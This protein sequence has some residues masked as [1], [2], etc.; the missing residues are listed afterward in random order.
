MTIV[1][2]ALDTIDFSDLEFYRVTFQGG[3]FTKALF[4]G[5]RLIDCSM[6]GTELQ[7]ASFDNA[8]IGCDFNGAS[9]KGATFL[10]ARFVPRTEPDRE[11]QRT[12]FKSAQLAD[13]RFKCALRYVDFRNAGFN[14]NTNFEG[15]DLRHA[16]LDYCEGNANFK[17]ANMRNASLKGSQL[18]KAVL[19]EADLSD[20]DVDARTNFHLA[21]VRSCKITRYTLACL[22]E[23]GGLTAG[24]RMD[25]DIVDDVAT[26]RRSYTGVI[27]WIYLMSLALFLFPYAWFVGRHWAVAR[28][29][30]AMTENTVALGEA[31]A[32]FILSGGHAWE[33]GWSLNVYAFALF[34]LTLLY[35]VLRGVLLWKTKALELEEQCSGLPAKFSLRVR[36]WGSLYKAAQIGFWVN[37]IVIALHTWHFLGQRIPV[38]SVVQ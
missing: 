17:G 29:S 32:R 36:P 30:G 14:A 26:L 19:V 38:G 16:T 1:G 13:A 2:K 34:L 5:A 6:R 8:T 37:I 20:T 7:E 4:D 25:M 3:S 10:D 27:Q 31:I 21:D 12:S 24:D 9:L 15:C 23:F 22:N 28:F 35:N 18:S 11:G 33:S